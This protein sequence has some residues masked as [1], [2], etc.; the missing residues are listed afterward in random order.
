MV[1]NRDKQED[2]Q[3]TVLWMLNLGELVRVGDTMGC[4]GH[5]VTC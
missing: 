3:A 1:G 5:I 2:S 4:W